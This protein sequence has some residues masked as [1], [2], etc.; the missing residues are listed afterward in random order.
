M[1]G[2]MGSGKVPTW[3]PYFPPLSHALNV[4]GISLPKQPPI[5]HQGR[6]NGI[7][8]AYI[9]ELVGRETVK[10]LGM[11]TGAST[12]STHKVTFGAE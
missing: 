10:R 11:K 5:L 9:P 3:G 7:L 4:V 1:G 6:V 2:V 8:R 12:L